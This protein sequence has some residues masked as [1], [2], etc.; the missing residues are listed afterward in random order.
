[1]IKNKGHLVGGIITLIWGITIILIYT[2][3]D[4]TERCPSIDIGPE[5]VALLL[6]PIFFGVGLIGIGIA[7]LY[8]IISIN[9][10][11]EE[12]IGE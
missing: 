10:K 1:M 4:Y 11:P 3:I 9:K 8:T 5:C 2:P 7:V 6:V 12:K